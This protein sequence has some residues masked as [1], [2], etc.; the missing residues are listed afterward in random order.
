MLFGTYG[1]WLKESV[2]AVVNL[3][4]LPK[5]FSRSLNDVCHDFTERPAF[6]CCAEAKLNR[7]GIEFDCMFKKKKI[8]YTP[9]KQE[10]LH[11]KLQVQLWSEK[12][13]D[14]HRAQREASRK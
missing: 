6:R 5:T 7:A 11:F 3:I 13:S 1:A 14:K 9:H 8:N 4:C 10:L 12:F 2:V